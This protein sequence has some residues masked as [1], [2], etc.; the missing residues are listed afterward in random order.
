MV[1]HRI[2]R[3]THRIL[4]LLAEWINSTT[5]HQPS[6]WM[7]IDTCQVKTSE[8]SINDFVKITLNLFIHINLE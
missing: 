6:W 5:Q 4:I 2:H 1:N 8:V 7:V 3:S